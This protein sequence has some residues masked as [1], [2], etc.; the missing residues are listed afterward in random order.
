MCRDEGTLRAGGFVARDIYFR[1]YERRDTTQL[2]RRNA[3]GY[4]PR[5]DVSRK[6]AFNDRDQW[7]LAIGSG[8]F[9]PRVYF[10]WVYNRG[11]FTRVSKV[12]HQQ[13]Q[14][15]RAD[16]G[17]L[18]ANPPKQ[19]NSTQFGINRETAFATCFSRNRRGSRPDKL[20]TPCR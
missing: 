10:P 15:Q 16:N 2:A 4:A 6:F 13:Q 5:N 1:S 11:R 8:K 12:R 3:R 20:R 9:R 19:S 18:K 14:P 17:V 7:P